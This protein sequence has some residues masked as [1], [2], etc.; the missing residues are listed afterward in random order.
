[1]TNCLENAVIVW[2]RQDLRLHDQAALNAAIKSGYPIISLYI[3][4]D[5]SEEARA[6]GGAQ[7]WW[8]HHSL[9][10]LNNDLIKLGNQL[11]LRHGKPLNMIY[12]LINKYN[13]QGI[14][15]SRC[16]EPYAIARDT[17]IKQSLKDRGIEAH[18]VN[19]SLLFEPWTILN[20]AGQPYKVF[21]QFWK[22]CFKNWNKISKPGELLPRELRSVNTTPQSDSILS[23][24][25]LPTTPNWAQ[26]F[27][28]YWTPGEAG[29][30]DHLQTFIEDIAESYR[31]HRSFPARHGTSRLSP[32]LHFGEISPQQ[33]V[34]VI[35]AHYPTG[36][37]TGPACY[38][39]Q[40]G[41]REFCHYLLYH[42][43]HMVDKPFRNNFAT[44]EWDYDD[45]LIQQWQRGLTGF[46]I[47]DAGMRQLW[48][49]GWMHN[50]VR[51]IVASFLAKDLFMDWKD[52]ER[53]FWDTLVD[54]DLAN[55]V[56]S[57]QWIAGCGADTAPYFRIFNPYLQSKKFDPQGV[58]IRKWVPE[59]A[60]LPDEYIHEPH[61]APALYLEIA[62]ITLG[63][64]YP[65]PM[66]N[67]REARG[68]ALNRYKQIKK[69]I[70]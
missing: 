65:Y 62:G 30:Q 27:F 14:Y 42:H 39:K 60:N 67:H 2:F 28:E 26:E 37:T 7:R 12:D 16:Y 32:H 57:W 52:G 49:M 25:L 31:Q 48:R 41:W 45:K 43:P 13:I 61:N 23:W 36:L 46:P 58:Y 55:N 63:K 17:A 3:Y 64:T 9:T 22:S 38:L 47:V 4:D 1:M 69:T 59:L 6:L 19:S 29:A 54:A 34:R 15:W 35:T 24:K 40:L 33:V 10:S 8:L 5:S 20:Q 66:V 44:L 70:D 11:I 68:R 53:W 50:R 51:M 18:S 56:A 21:S